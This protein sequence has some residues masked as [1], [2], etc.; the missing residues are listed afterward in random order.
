MED[1]P[2]KGLQM[3]DPVG[4]PH[5]RAWVQVAAVS[6][7]QTINTFQLFHGL[8]SPKCI[9]EHGIDLGKTV[10]YAYGGKKRIQ[11]VTSSPKSLEGNR[12]T[13]VVMNET[14][15]W[16]SNNDGIAMAEAI[17]RNATKA[18]GGASRTL[19]ITNAYEPGTD[20]AA[21][22]QREAYLDAKAG[23]AMDSGVCYDSL[24]APKDARLRPQF[25]D[26]QDGAYRK[27]VRELPT[28]LKDELTRRYL[29]RVLEVVRGGAW[30][31]DIPGITDSIVS[32]KN[33]QSTS[34]RFW[35]N[36][37]VSTEDAWL[38]AAA[39]DAAISR[40]AKENRL[41]S[42]RDADEQLKAGWLV[43]PNE[44]IVMFFDGS[45]SD[46]S[47]GLVGCRLSDGYV[48]TIG[49]W[50]KPA[51]E[52]GKGWLAPRAQVDARVDEAF[53]RFN[54]VA[55]WGDPSHTKD[56]TDDS[57][58]W[59]GMLDKWMRVYKDRLDSKHWPVKSGLSRHAINFDMTG[60]ER[61]RVFVEAAETFRDEMHTLNDVEEYRP[62]FEIDGHPALVAHLKNA[63][64]YFHPKGYGT[65]LIK[66]APDSPRKIDLAVCAV[67][68]RLL[69]RVVLNLHEE[70]E[71]KDP[72]VI[73]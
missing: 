11:A 21:R 66:D 34:R 1:M 15:H 47:T 9:A 24:E 31:L 14:H 54:I 61:Q 69:R 58:Y 35:F 2:E 70:E 51:G 39:I 18:K 52:R 16:H 46:D 26:E 62:A 41:I 33:L 19:S 63:I 27:G 36:Q 20:S 59:M 30:W 32:P 68:A 38:D 37:V 17:E 43:A 28:E 57:S 40:M 5:P 42:S 13:L 3:G 73:W 29:R 53:K 64:S 72:G 65:S 22:R 56:E 10:I 48:F 71:V 55:F 49:V 12:P 6:L 44:P 4:K 23:L 60:P 45:K 25:P 8:F 67:G 50:Q 7:E